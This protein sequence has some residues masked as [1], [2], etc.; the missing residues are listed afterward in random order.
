MH[1]LSPRL[2]SSQYDAMLK[3]RQETI[4]FPQFDA[5][6][7]SISESLALYRATGLANHLV[8]YGSTGCGKTTVCNF[9]LGENPP[10][11]GGERNV[12]PV[13]YASIPALATISSVAEALL[14]SL[15]DPFPSKGT[16]SSKTERLISLIQRCS[17]A[18]VILDELQHVHD[19]GQSPALYKVGDWIKNL[20]DRIA[21]P[22]VLVGIPR[23]KALVEANEQLRRRFGTSLILD[24]I[25]IDTDESFAEFGDVV[26]SLSEALP[27]GFRCNPQS[28]DTVERLYFATDGRIGYLAELLQKALLSSF[29]ADNA[30]ID[31]ALLQKTFTQRIWS[32]G[33][34]KLNPFHKD[35]CFR[36]LDRLGEPF[37]GGDTGR[38]D[39][40]VAT[41]WLESNRAEAIS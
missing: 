33:I 37:N 31:N 26:A 23:A 12:I 16:N 41:N 7:R 34:G 19:R 15:G 39:V 28:H 21:C 35:F 1:E 27:V 4:L 3:F 9:V 29:Q 6:Y 8:V 14:V 22:V 24:R 30:P 32:N 10:V 25:T 36:R 13:L 2:T 40:R 17:V 38:A 20:S 11:V 18:M 5:V